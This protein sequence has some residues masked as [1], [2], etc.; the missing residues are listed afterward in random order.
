VRL[1]MDPPTP[2]KARMEHQRES[3]PD[4]AVMAEPAAPAE[5]GRHRNPS[6]AAVGDRHG[7]PGGRW[8]G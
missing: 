4:A 6:I 3:T 1:A 7:A 2:P 8:P 5:G